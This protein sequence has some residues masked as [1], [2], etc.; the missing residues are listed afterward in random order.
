MITCFTTKN[1][2]DYIRM[3]RRGR[4]KFSPKTPP[5]AWLHTIQRD[6]IRKAFLLGEQVWDPTSDT[7]AQ[8]FYTRQLSPQNAWLRKLT[9]LMS[10]G[11]KK[12]LETETPL[13][14]GS[15]AILLTQRPCKISTV[16]KL[17]RLFVKESCLQI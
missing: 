7:R 2:K 11:P 3:G 5:L 12:L 14:K 15:H 10:K 8:E 1:K 16:C 4:E 6:L 9:G 13:L 17:L